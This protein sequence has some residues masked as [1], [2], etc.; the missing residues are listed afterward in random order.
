[1]D[2]PPDHIAREHLN[3]TR[4][5]HDVRPRQMARGLITLTPVNSATLSLYN[6]S[7]G[8]RL[9]VVRAY[10]L[11]TTVAHLVLVQLQQGKQGTV[12]GASAPTIPGEAVNGTLYSLDTATALTSPDY[13][14]DLPYNR[15][16]W[17]YAFPFQVLHPGWSLT[18]QDTTAAELMRLAIMWEA[19]Y[20]DQLDFF[21]L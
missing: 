5:Y 10:N 19:I 3:P 1:M 2:H 17:D 12:G 8:D 13:I 6:E 16:A 7:L 11:F 21:R 14:V 20:P 15:P 18:F 9:L 4:Q